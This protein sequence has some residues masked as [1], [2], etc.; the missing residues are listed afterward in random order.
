MAS[1]SHPWLFPGMSSPPPAASTAVPVPS[2]CKSSK[3]FASLRHRRNAGSVAPT[4][5]RRCT[6]R[7]VKDESIHFDPSKIEAP[8]YSSYFDSTSGQLE[9]AS[10]A[11]AS[12]PGQEYWPE[13]TAARVRAA[14]APAPVGESA[15]TPSLGKKPGSRRKGYKGQVAS[16]SAAGGADTGGDDGEFIVATEV[17]L[18][19]TLEETNDSL[20]EY[21]IYEAPKEESL[22]EYEMDK[23]MGRPHPFVDPAKAMLAEEPKS[24][25]E[26]WWNWRRKSEAEMWSR[27]QRRRPDVD[28]VFAKAMAETGQIKIFG[29]HPTRTE[30][31]LAKTRR[32]LHKEERL[33]AEQRRLEEIGPIAYYSEWVEAYEQKDTSW[34]AIQKHFEETGEDA[35]TQLITMFQ[36]QTAGEY[37]IMMGTDVRI[38]RD[39]LAMRMRED[40]IKQIWGG[41]P[42]YPTV[43]YVQDPDEVIDYRSPEFHEPT[44]EVVPYLMEHGI[45][46]TKEELDARLMEEE[47]D[48][49]QDITYIPEVKDPMSTAVDIGEHSFNEDSDDDEEV[50]KA[51][52]LPESLEDEEDG[53]DEAAEVEGK[54]SQNWSVLKTTGQD[55]KPKEKLKKDQMSLKDAIN[56]SENL[57]DFLMDFEEDE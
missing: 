20:D 50:D 23:M 22:S 38:Q 39:P 18:D 33:E 1:C 14:R 6:I 13:G 35:N 15:G 41:D 16:A 48:I 2:F 17:P 45:M 54:V 49:N 57:T 52:T 10:G 29:D 26:L 12:I 30:A 46:I 4:R 37:R 24:S 27:W 36:H 28:T 25:E 51:V 5:T 44:P 42:V 7:C 55:E 9:P 8:P 31:A 40:Q 34:E 32:H 3:V 43:N 11:R 47:E 21:V 19:D 56:E 53:G